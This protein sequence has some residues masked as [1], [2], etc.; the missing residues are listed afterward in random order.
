MEVR[1]A[2]CFKVKIGPGR[3]LDFAAAQEQAMVM[4]CAIDEYVVFAVAGK[5]WQIAFD[6]Q[7]QFHGGGGCVLLPGKGGSG[8]IQRFARCC[9]I[10]QFGR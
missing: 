7:V 5:E 6:I 3:N 10:L 8:R 9:F 4:A 2:E 1:C